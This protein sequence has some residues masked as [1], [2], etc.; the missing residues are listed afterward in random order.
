MP[1]FRIRWEAENLVHSI[2][3]PSGFVVCGGECVLAGA[4]A[5]EVE[6]QF[7]DLP[8]NRLATI[9]VTGEN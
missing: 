3:G 8:G 2:K 9:N 6:R 5:A 7:R 1:R 4:S